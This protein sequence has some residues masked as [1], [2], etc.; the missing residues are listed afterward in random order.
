M[1]SNCP[2]IDI[3]THDPNN[4]EDTLSIVNCFY[5]ETP[6]KSGKLFSYG[7]HPWHIDSNFNKNELKNEIQKQLTKSN[8]IAI[9]ETGLDKKI[10]IDIDLQLDF[11][12]IQLNLSEELQKPVIIHSVKTI[13]EIIAIRKEIKATQPWIFH[14]FNSSVQAAKQITN[15]GC[16]ISFGK[17]ILTPDPK[18]TEI[19]K[20]L[21][22]NYLFFETDTSELSIKVIYQRASEILE[23]S[24]EELQNKIFSNFHKIFPNVR[25]E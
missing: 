24:I 14:G 18:D 21:N 17:R 13:N 10:N 23:T 11:F 9:G 12:K 15:S 1:I 8:I 16:F 4:D 2:Y 5:G 3:H 19:L 6:L 22:I 25:K 20:Q 7:L